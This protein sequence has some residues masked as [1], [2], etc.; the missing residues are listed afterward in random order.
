M[1]R[2][3]KGRAK[4]LDQE[5]RLNETISQKNKI[6]ERQGEVHLD[7]KIVFRVS[8]AKE[9]IV[10]MIASDHGISRIAHTSRKINVKWE[11]IVHS[12][13]KPTKEQ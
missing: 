10:V 5:A 2:Q 6:P 13:A 11:R 3:R 12:I 8:I 7:K 4:E 9:E 1:T